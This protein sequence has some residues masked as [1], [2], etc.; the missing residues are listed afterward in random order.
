MNITFIGH[1]FISRHE[2][3][4]RAVKELVKSSA[5]D[6]ELI[7]CY[8]GGYGEF[9]E[10][11]AD[12]CRELKQEI[13]TIKLVYVTPYLNLS[14]QA[15]IKDMNKS[16][17]YDEIFYPPIESTPP[18]FAIS[19][20]NDWMIKNADLVIAYVDHNHGGAY[21]SLQKAIRRKKNIINVCDII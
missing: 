6:S 15:K 21:K 7:V 2:T 17:L 5:C 1:S 4:K 3:V 10:I 20:R 12:A 19:K 9:D 11:C 18:R 16:F 13:D 8:L 14:E